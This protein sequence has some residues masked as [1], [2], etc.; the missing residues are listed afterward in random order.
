VQWAAGRSPHRTCYYAGE[1]Y[2]GRPT[3]VFAHFALP[4]PLPPG[5]PVPAMVLV[6]GG[7]GR[8]FPHWATQWAQRGYAALAMDLCGCGPDG[9]PL[10]DGGPALSDRNA[11]YGIASGPQGSW[12]YHAVAAVIRAVS[13]LRHQPE[14]DPDRIGLTGISWGGYLACIVAGLDDRLR[15]AVPVYG[16]GY[17][18]RNSVWKPM[19][20]GMPDGQRTAWIDAFEPS[21]YLPGA[22]LPMFWVSGTND[23]AY[24]L[25]S[26]QRSYRLAPGPRTLRITV[27][28]PH[29]HSA[30]MDPLE[31]GAFADAQLRGA[32]PLPELGEVQRDGAVVRAPLRSRLP[33]QTA[34]LHYSADAIP[35]DH[36]RWSSVPA[37]V[38]ED[39]VEARLPDERPLLYFFTVTDLRGA[40][41]STDYA[42]LPRA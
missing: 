26:L 33:I 7:G 41:V 10:P 2:E 32:T 20:D 29:G 19:L 42:E 37:A 17:L 27:N 6:H 14:V 4:D 3:R 38:G 21:C 9:A 12:V 36:R 30:G 31:I 13:V 1:P 39:A 40:V 28:M 23:G 8:A 11:F 16:C 5:G 15:L 25:D 24:A 35:W 34:T 18:H 22:R